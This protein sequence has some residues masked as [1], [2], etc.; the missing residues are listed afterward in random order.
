MM[1]A[2]RPLR[3]I[4]NL[5]LDRTTIKL[6]CIYMSASTFYNISTC[7]IFLII[8]NETSW[9]N[10]LLLNFRLYTS[11]DDTLKFQGNGSEVKYYFSS[12]FS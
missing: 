8:N 2:V 11:Y 9:H 1:L 12:K 10:H 3:M 5:L 4:L 7:S 6:A